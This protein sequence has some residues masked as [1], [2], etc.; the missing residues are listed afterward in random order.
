MIWV[1]DVLCAVGWI[2]LCCCVSVRFLLFLMGWCVL[3]VMYCVMLYECCF[4][5]VCELLCDDACWIMCVAVC[6]FF[7]LMCVCGL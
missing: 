4:V 2:G 7:G 6:V 5:C 3:F 1:Y